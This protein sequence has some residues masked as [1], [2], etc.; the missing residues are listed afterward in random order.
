[1]TF[2]GVQLVIAL[3]V[4]P[5]LWKGIYRG[6]SAIFAWIAFGFTVLSL[7]ITYQ[8]S[9]WIGFGA[10]VLVFLALRRERSARIALVIFLVLCVVAAVSVPSIRGK[11]LST[12]DFSQANQMERLQMW[13]VAWNIGMEHPLTGVGPGM[14]GPYAWPHLP[15]SMHHMSHAHNDLLQIWATTGIGGTLS[16]LALAGLL[17]FVGFREL[18]KQPGV[19]SGSAHSVYQGALIAFLGFLI[20]SLFQCYLIDGENAI[21]MGMILGLGLAARDSIGFHS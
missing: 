5:S 17:L 16:A 3:A 12:F 11:L 20:A 4:L 18:R 1:M 9:A 2:A 15:E 7:V 13:P 10:G 19:D 21:A 8:R 14:F 6:R